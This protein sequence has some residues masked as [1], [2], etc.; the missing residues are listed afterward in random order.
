MVRRYRQ[1]TV[2]AQRAD[3]G[4]W[5]VFEKASNWLSHLRVATAPLNVL[6]YGDTQHQSE[7]ARRSGLI[8]LSGVERARE[9]S[10]RAHRPSVSGHLWGTDVDSSGV[11]FGLHLA[12]GGDEIRHLLVGHLAG[13]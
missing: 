7:R 1:S 12:G 3:D 9:D 6:A 10:H 11:E 13:E 5:E 8:A 4:G 2:R